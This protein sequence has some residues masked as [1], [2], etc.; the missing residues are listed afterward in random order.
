MRRYL[1]TAHSTLQPIANPGPSRQPPAPETP[2]QSEQ[3][4]FK[5]NR[6]LCYRDCETCGVPSGHSHMLGCPEGEVERER[7]ADRDTSGESQRNLTAESNALASDDDS[8]ESDPDLEERKERDE[9]KEKQMREYRVAQAKRRER[10]RKTGKGKG[11][12]RR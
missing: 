5:M 7:Y 2:Q 11:K 9:A 4:D 12:G 1:R 3:D 10:E 6:N 8:F